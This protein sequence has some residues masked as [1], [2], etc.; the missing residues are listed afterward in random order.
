[1][2]VLLKLTGKIEARRGAEPHRILEL[3]ASEVTSAIRPGESADLFYGV[4]DRRSFELNY[5]KTKGLVALHQDFS[6][7]E[8][9]ILDSQSEAM[10]GPEFSV[11]KTQLMS[12]N[13]RDRLILCTRGLVETENLEGEAFGQER[14]FKS[15]LEGP[16]QG[17]HEL[18]NHVLY[19][20]HKFSGGQEPKRDRTLLVLEVKDRVI[21]L[22]RK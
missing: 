4:V 8:L 1:L 11:L 18:R 20:V 14:L 6:T 15:V 3:V 2:S 12:L 17:V 9:K 7:G 16:R 19:E 13:S 22:A 10:Q 5:A 21:K